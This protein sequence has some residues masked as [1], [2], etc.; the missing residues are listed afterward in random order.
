VQQSAN[1]SSY[2]PVRKCVC[3]SPRNNRW[4]F[5]RCR[6]R[7]NIHQ[8]DIALPAL[9]ATQIA[10]RHAGFQRQ[11]FPRTANPLTDIL[12]P[13]FIQLGLFLKIGRMGRYNH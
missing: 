5:Q 11:R 4:Q 6:Q 12:N 13:S 10:A 7:A 1:A 2:I 3:K 8:R 9:N